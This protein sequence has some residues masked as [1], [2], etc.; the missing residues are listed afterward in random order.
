VANIS[1]VIYIEK[2]IL[3]AIKERE[4]RKG[5]RNRGIPTAT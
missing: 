5:K 1:V 4:K 2:K 3:T